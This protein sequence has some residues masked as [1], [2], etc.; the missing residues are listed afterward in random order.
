MEAKK[1]NQIQTQT[2]KRRS[3][4][5]EGLVREAFNEVLPS[6]AKEYD[7]FEGFGDIM[8]EF[9]TPDKHFQPAPN[10]QAYVK[11]AAAKAEQKAPTPL[12]EE[13]QLQQDLLRAQQ[14]DPA[15]NQ[16][17]EEYFRTRPE[18]IAEHG[19]L[20]L[21]A[22]NTIISSLLKSEPVVA[23]HV[24]R[25]NEQLADSLKRPGCSSLEQLAVDR[26]VIANLAAAVL[27][28]LLAGNIGKPELHHKTARAHELAEKRIQTAIKTLD[29][30]RDMER[31]RGQNFDPLLATAPGRGLNS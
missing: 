20:A 31:R 30:V 10:N 13:Q 5:A 22:R 14:G 17:V 9:G 6:P 24:R 12:N 26:I 8:S 18:Q 27:D 19:N 7:P 11:P 25:H 15:A 1:M 2:P 21:Q 4:Q 16:R 28:T 3:T 23:E 29:L